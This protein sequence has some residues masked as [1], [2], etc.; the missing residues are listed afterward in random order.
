VEDYLQMQRALTDLVKE[1]FGLN[2]VVF[3]A[4]NL[5]EAQSI[6][7]Q[8]SLEI[9]LILM[10]TNLGNGDNTYQLTTDISKSFTKPIVATS[11]DKR[12]FQKMLDCGCTHNCEKADL[13]SF[14]ESL[15]EKCDKC[16]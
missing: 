14:L 6:F 3:I 16:S 11:I 9:D 15:K 8:H 2:T 7:A 4:G 10:D 13:M 5:T 1:V 12:N